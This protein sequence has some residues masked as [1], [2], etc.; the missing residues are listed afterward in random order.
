MSELGMLADYFSWKGMFANLL[1]VLRGIALLTMIIALA[2]PQQILK[3]EEIKAEGIDIA[4]VI[5]LSSSMLRSR[6]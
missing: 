1:P 5:D 3:E 6:L 4:L 2:R